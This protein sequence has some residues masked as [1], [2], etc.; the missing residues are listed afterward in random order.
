MRSLVVSSEGGRDTEAS[1]CWENERMCTQAV[2][3]T[4]CWSVS[5]SATQGLK[6]GSTVHIFKSHQETHSQIRWSWPDARAESAPQNKRAPRAVTGG[7]TPL[8]SGKED[9]QEHETLAILPRGQGVQP[10]A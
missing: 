1:G 4:D 5:Y 8:T 10:Q 2:S 6:K 3:W 9:S 7:K